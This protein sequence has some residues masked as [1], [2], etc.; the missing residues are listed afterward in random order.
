MSLK[1]NVDVIIGMRASINQK[2]RISHTIQ[3]DKIL[4]KRVARDFLK[5]E[6]L[7]SSKVLSNNL[8][9]IGEGQLTLQHEHKRDDG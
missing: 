2:T 4:A 3:A 8:T 5:A 6:A 7:D 1:N 9:Y